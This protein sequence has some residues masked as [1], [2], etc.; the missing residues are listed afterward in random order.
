M[1]EYMTK[2]LIYTY[3]Y[4]SKLLSMESILQLDLRNYLQDFVS[5]VFKYCD[6]HVD[7]TYFY[8]KLW[9]ARF[10]VNCKDLYS[11]LACLAKVEA[12]QVR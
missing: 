2:F 6:G 9:F 12:D 4:D 10:S 5:F 3:V 11:V 1:K 8:Y 7:V